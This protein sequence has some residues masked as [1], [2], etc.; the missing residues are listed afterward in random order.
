MIIRAIKFSQ[1]KVDTGETGEDY[2]KFSNHS[3][4]TSEIMEGKLLKQAVF[5]LTPS[6]N[7]S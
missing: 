7:L 6:T 5:N 2:M 4:E 3:V 1:N